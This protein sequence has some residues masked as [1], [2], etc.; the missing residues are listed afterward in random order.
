VNPATRNP[1][2]PAG[3]GSTNEAEFRIA[4]HPDRTGKGL[5]R[6]VTLATLK[7]GFGQLGLEKIYL[8]VR[9]NNSRAFKLYQSAGFA[10]TG[11][12][13][14]TIQGK[15]IAFIDM[16]MTRERFDAAGIKEDAS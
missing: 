2:A 11:E 10:E 14:H 16:S 7:K 1:P 13:V 12:S 5:G 8:I 4:L 3:G 9:K 6:K 15:G